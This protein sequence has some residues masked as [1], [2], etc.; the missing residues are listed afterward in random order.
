MY[1]G[2][3]VGDPELRLVSRLANEEVGPNFIRR[4]SP[5]AV[6][7]AGGADTPT[8]PLLYVFAKCVFAP[9]HIVS[10]DLRSR[11]INRAAVSQSI[12][13]LAHERTPLRFGT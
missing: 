6:A 4:V 1:R 5:V 11:I 2:V 3:G 12:A 8:R 7:V 9:R 13:I 10:T